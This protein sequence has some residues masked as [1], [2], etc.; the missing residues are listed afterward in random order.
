MGNMFS[1]PTFVLSLVAAVGVFVPSQNLTYKMLTILLVFALSFA[2]GLG[3]Y[4]WDCKNSKEKLLKDK[5]LDSAKLTWIMPVVL[6]VLWI[7]QYLLNKVPIPGIKNIIAD[8]IIGKSPCRAFIIA[9]T[10]F[11]VLGGMRE[12]SC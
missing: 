10:A 12:G 8:V 4:S 1:L 7:V 2:A 9:I 11:L 3:A 6:L 5:A